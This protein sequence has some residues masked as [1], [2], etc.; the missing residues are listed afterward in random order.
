MAQIFS[1]QNEHSLHV[2]IDVG[3]ATVKVIALD[4]HSNKTLYAIYRRHYAH[5]S[6][7]LAPILDEIASTFPRTRIRMAVTGANGKSIA[8]I[9]GVPYVPETIANPIA[10]Q[11][12]APT[13]AH[14]LEIGAKSTRLFTYARDKDD[15]LFVS[16]IRVSDARSNGMGTF[17]DE[18]ANMLKIPIESLDYFAADS[19][20]EY[21]IS[22]GCGLY[23]KVG[24]RLLLDGGASR[25]GLAR[26]AFRA[27]A[28]QTLGEL[29]HDIVNIRTPIVFSGGPLSFNPEL[30]SIFE[31][32]LHITPEDVIIPQHSESFEAFGCAL[33]L[34]DEL[35]DAAADFDRDRAQEY[36]RNRRIFNLGHIVDG[37]R[38]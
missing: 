22:Q 34:S 26:S 23:T 31:K 24:I 37:V 29:A 32:Q 9:L 11:A 33:S 2:G 1:L 30:V 3:T 36:L 8:D 25:N 4:G 18:I 13:A 16:N 21:N 5:Q 38:G 17:I 35:E 15:R 27:V 10:V 20:H 12:A 14:T 7:R 6:A 19:T 28:Q